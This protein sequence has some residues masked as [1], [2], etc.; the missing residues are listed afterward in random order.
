[1]A[2]VCSLSARVDR[3]EAHADTRSESR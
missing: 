1:V 3:L 2:V